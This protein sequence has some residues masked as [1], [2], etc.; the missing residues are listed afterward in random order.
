MSPSPWLRG[1]SWGGKENGILNVRGG[2]SRVELL[3]PP[4]LIL[5][6]GRALPLAF[7]SGH[8]LCFHCP[9]CSVSG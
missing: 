8:R 5:E 6:S 9:I 1:F 4:C 2:A 3:I 7:L